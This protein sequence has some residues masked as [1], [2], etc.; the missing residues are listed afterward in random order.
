MTVTLPSRPA[1]TQ[2]RP[3]AGERRGQPGMIARLLIGLVRF[4]QAARYGHPSPC[5]YVPT[6]SAYAVEALQRH[7]AGRGAWLTAR[8]IGR[9]HPWGGHGVDPVPE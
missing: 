1:P 2:A 4:Y 7:G 6:C 3:P 9:C 8:R 5:R